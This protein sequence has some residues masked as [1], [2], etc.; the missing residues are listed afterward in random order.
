MIHITANINQ[1]IIQEM[2]QNIPL[3]V[4]VLLKGKPFI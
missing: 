2:K 3:H 1:A 4:K